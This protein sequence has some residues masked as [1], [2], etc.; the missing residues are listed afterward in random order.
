M[1]A[2]ACRR[3]GR[4]ED[5]SGDRGKAARE[6]IPGNS[7]PAAAVMVFGRAE[8]ARCEAGQVVPHTAAREGDAAACRHVAVTRNVSPRACRAG[9][10]CACGRP[11]GGKKAKSSL[12]RE[13]GWTIDAIYGKD[14][15]SRVRG[16]WPEN[17][18][19][20]V[21]QASFSSR[22]RSAFFCLPFVAAATADRRAAI[23]VADVLRHSGDLCVPTSCV[24]VLG[25]AC[26]P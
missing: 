23:P 3:A 4:A 21:V 9:V 16:H 22:K 19:Q 18:R 20:C 26:A 24:P 5:A 1:A 6:G 8:G 2:T 13:S 15:K 25:R 12:Q 7:L 14:L 10:Q 11:F 17:A